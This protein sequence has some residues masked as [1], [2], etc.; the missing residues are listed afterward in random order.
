MSFKMVDVDYKKND[1]VVSVYNTNLIS[2]DCPDENNVWLRCS[3]NKGVFSII[4]KRDTKRE[5]FEYHLTT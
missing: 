4:F 5:S 2:Y 1:I 3:N